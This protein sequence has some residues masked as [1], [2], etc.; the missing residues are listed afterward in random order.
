MST[1]RRQMKISN[2][3]EFAH[4]LAKLVEQAVNDLNSPKGI[5]LRYDKR[6]NLKDVDYVLNGKIEE[7]PVGKLLILCEICDV[8]LSIKSLKKSLK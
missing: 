7:L 2:N 6:I 4:A 3:L 8:H 1:K 5:E